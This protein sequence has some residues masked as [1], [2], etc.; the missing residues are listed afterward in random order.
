MIAVARGVLSIY[1]E[2]VYNLDQIMWFISERRTL[3]H[4]ST[5]AVVMT[6]LVPPMSMLGLPKMEVQTIFSTPVY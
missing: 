4:P 3:S 5:I 1:S 6:P 2:L